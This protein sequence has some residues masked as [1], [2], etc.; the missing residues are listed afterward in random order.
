MFDTFGVSKPGIKEC[1]GKDPHLGKVP[2]RCER[3]LSRSRL[4]RE[5]GI[6]WRLCR[7]AMPKGSGDAES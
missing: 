4:E 2:A 6:S 7:P 1:D 5:A 3:E